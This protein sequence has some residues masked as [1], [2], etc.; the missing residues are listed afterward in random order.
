MR[1]EE[2]WEWDVT[3]EM[4]KDKVFELSGPNN[5]IATKIDWDKDSDNCMMVG[6][7]MGAGTGKHT[8]SMKLDQGSANCMYISCGVVSDGALWYIAS[9]EGDICKLDSDWIVSSNEAG[10][11]KSGQ[12]LTMQVDTDASTL[13]FWV[14]GKPH[15]PGFTSGVTGSLRWKTWVNYEGNAVEIV[16]TPE[17]EYES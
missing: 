5:S 17:L 8:I 9:D 10:E 3:A 14:D 13:K 4:V 1:P 15:G 6:R 12:V 11:I 2:E 16:P 7:A